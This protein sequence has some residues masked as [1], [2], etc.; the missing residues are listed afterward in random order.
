MQCFRVGY[1]GICH[2]SLV[3]SVY[4]RAFR[5]VCVRRKY[6]LQVAFSTVS[7]EEA[8][9]NYFIPCLDL[10]KTYGNFGKSSE[11]SANFRKLRKCFKPV[12]EEHKRFMKLLENFGNSSKVFS[13]CFY[14]FLNF[15]ENLRKF[16]EV[17]GNHR[18]FSENFG[19][20]SKVIF[21]C[22]Y[23][24]LKFLENLRKS[25]EVFGNL[26]KFSENF[27]N[28]SKVIFRCF[29]DFLKFSE[30]LRK[31]SDVFENLGKRFSDVI[32][33]VRNGSQELKDFGDRFW[34]VFK[35]TPVNRCAQGM[36][37]K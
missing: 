23:D 26:R 5:R 29:Y 9:H 21:R 36:T 4:T 1:S 8:L 7:H 32:G 20:G 10:R 2:A 17:F 27:G 12:F 24:F 15:S 25:S 19:N 13:R 37:G 14:D 31:S 34:E 16:L 6:K 33:N 3:F 28:G 35:W 22:F 30:N 11:I 18:K